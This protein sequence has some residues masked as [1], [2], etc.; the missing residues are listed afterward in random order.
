MSVGAVLVGLAIA[1]VAG[2]YVARPLLARGYRTRE[3]TARERLLAE[4]EGLYTAIRDLD[5]DY[6]TGRVDEASYR[7]LRATLTA[8]AAD[9][10]RRLD[11]LSEEGDSL[12]AEIEARVARLRARRA[13]GR[14][15]GREV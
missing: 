8:Q 6:Q 2:A 13:R 12:D 9:V 4:R 5:F 14:R 3:P 15:G 11:A 7:E 1:V 10:L